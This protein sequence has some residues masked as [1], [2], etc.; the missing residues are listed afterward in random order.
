MAW[1]QCP[2]SESFYYNESDIK[3][4]LKEELIFE[5]SQSQSVCDSGSES[6]PTLT[7]LDNVGYITG[8]GNALLAGDDSGKYTAYIYI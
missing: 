6:P 8:D 3:L 7:T 2:Q 1:E 4:K 5:D